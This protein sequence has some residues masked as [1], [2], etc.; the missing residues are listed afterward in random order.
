MKLNDLIDNGILAETQHLHYKIYSVK[1]GVRLLCN[2]VAV[3]DIVYDLDY[4]EYI[5]R[6]SGSPNIRY[7]SKG[8]N[9]RFVLPESTNG[10]FST[11][12]VTARELE[13]FF[14]SQGMNL[15]KDTVV[16][17]PRN[18]KLSQSTSVRSD[19]F[20][21]VDDLCLRTEIS[22][23]DPE[24]LFLV[25]RMNA[26]VMNDFLT[27]QDLRM[28][29]ILLK[30]VTNKFDVHPS[31]EVYYHLNHPRNVFSVISITEEENC[32]VIFYELPDNHR[33]STMSIGKNE[34][35]FT[36]KLK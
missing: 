36:A 30:D 13:D 6:Y 16:Y 14:L 11:Y 8:D 19:V 20:V 32:I 21:F 34:K 23:D 33:I 4:D 10:V 15:Q 18:S 12:R 9:F 7:I 26:L 1:S 24:K 3:D 22:F 31:Y 28:R 17:L 35:Y 29:N 25:V 27:M 5:G 2:D